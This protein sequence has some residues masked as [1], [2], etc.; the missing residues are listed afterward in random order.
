M[1]AHGDPERGRVIIATGLGESAYAPH[2]GDLNLYLAGNAGGFEDWLERYLANTQVTPEIIL[3]LS[4]RSCTLLEEKGF[5]TIYFPYAIDPALFY[6]MEQERTGLGYSGLN[7]KSKEQMQTVLDPVKNREDFEWISKQRPSMTV[8]GLN[9][10]LNTKKIV[11]G[12]LFEVNEKHGLTNSDRIFATLASGTPIIMS[13]QRDLEDIL[14]F[15]Y[16]FQ[17]RTRDET[18]QLTEQILSD[19]PRYLNIFRGYS[20]VVRR[21]HTYLRRFEHLFEHLN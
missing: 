2:R 5:K 3:C 15:K 8:F 6:P 16:P 7:S 11:Y 13:Y 19:Y 20:N 17:T 9:D 4:P 1:E 18:V 14:G 21:E 10:W 12:M